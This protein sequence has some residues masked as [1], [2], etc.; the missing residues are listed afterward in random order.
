M[1]I[2]VPC[3]VLRLSLLLT[4]LSLARSADNETQVANPWNCRGSSPVAAVP[5]CGLPYAG[6]NS[7]G[8]CFASDPYSLTS[9]SYCCTALLSACRLLTVASHAG[10]FRC[11][12]S[13][14]MARPQSNDELLQ[15]I[16]ENTKVKGAG[17]GHSW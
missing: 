10:W 2:P 17:V 1:R 7:Y 6:T 16:K 12:A 4:S 9:T 15:L 5:F 3:L 14:R 8:K 13:V 11:D